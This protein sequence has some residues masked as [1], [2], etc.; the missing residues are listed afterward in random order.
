[1][2]PDRA[3]NARQPELP[4]AVDRVAAIDRLLPQT[5]CRRCGYAG[6][7]PYAEAMASGSAPINRCPPGGTAVVTALARL[8]GT[9]PLALDPDCGPT[10]ARSV[11]SVD[12]S[13]CIG[14]T[15][16]IL[17]CPVDAIVGAP[18]HQ[19]H[20]LADRCTGCAL[21][22]P[23]CPADCIVM[24]PLAQEWSAADAARGRRH[25]R[26]RLDRLDRQG[27]AIAADAPP[28]ADAAAKAGAARDPLVVL[29]APAERSRRLQQILE[30]VRGAGRA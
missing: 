6:C 19:H 3:S 20:V 4:D 8:L 13:R 5:Q 11:A 21:C 23:P 15:K 22:L 18:R 28:G 30:R 9:A 14:C 2:R 25:H 24:E 7:L 17:A 26:A 10:P 16:C 1:M 27:R 29:G 12:N